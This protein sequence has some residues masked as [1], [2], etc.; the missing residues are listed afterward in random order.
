M[1]N[2]CNSQKPE[3][4]NLRDKKLKI[5]VLMCILSGLIYMVIYSCLKL[6]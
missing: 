6:I 1:E 2:N 3:I 4:E 5:Q